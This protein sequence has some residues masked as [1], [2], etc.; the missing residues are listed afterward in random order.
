MALRNHPV[1][2]AATFNAQAAE[3]VTREAKS[4]YL[5]TANG[6]LTGAGAMSNSRIAAGYL[7]NPYILNRYSNGLAVSQLITDFGHT[8]NLVA[9]AR[10]GAQAASQSAKQ[11]EQ[12]VLLGINRAYFGVLRAEA[13][14]K[15][16]QETVKARQILADQVTTLEKNKLK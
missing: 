12:D 6:S 3:Q 8:T 10:L 5:P 1:L 4:A 13:V 16:A 11:T 15:V 7:N 9:S 2:Q 14:L